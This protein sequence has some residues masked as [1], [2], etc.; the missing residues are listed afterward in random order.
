MKPTDYHSD[1]EQSS[2]ALF[3]LATHH[4]KAAQ[5]VWTSRRPTGFGGEYHPLIDRL[6]VWVTSIRHKG[7]DFIEARIFSSD[8]RLLGTALRWT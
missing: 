3:L 5:E 6:E 8:G 1:S 2:P 4:G 7:P